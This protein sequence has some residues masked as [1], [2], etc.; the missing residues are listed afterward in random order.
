MRKLIRLRLLICLINGHR[1]PCCP[2][3]LLFALS[4]PSHPHQKHTQ[5]R[6]APSLAY[7]SRTTD[8][9]VFLV[10]VGRIE[11]PSRTLF[12]LLHTAIKNTLREILTPVPAE[13][14]LSLLHGLRVPVHKCV[15]Y[16]LYHERN[17]LSSLIWYIRKKTLDILP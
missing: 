11:L 8:I 14:E 3:L 6:L 7:I 10:E 2:L 5:S 13:R 1:L 12:S 17:G 15:K 4:K 16:V 9:N